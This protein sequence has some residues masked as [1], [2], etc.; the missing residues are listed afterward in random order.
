MSPT[1]IIVSLVIA[2]LVRVVLL[3]VKLLN[4][5]KRPRIKLRNLR[6]ERLSTRN[7][8]VRLCGEDYGT[9]GQ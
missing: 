4:F 8:D 6:I 7:K 3:T 5:E 9:A 1:A 2:H